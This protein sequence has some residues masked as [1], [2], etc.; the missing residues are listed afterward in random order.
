MSAVETN[1][2]DYPEYPVFK[3]LQRPLEFLGLQG[4]YIYWG[5]GAVGGG[6]IGF[7]VGHIC[8][9]FLWGLLICTVALAVGGIFIFVKQRKGLHSKKEY[10]G[11]FI[12]YRLMGD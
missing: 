8:I 1:T 11:V 10:K 7:F 2:F 9:G 6:I 3:G 12:A 4:R 5:A